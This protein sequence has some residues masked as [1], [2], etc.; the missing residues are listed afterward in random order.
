M[1]PYR[2]LTEKEIATMVV[3]G[4]SAEDWKNVT[5]AEN[6]NPQFVSNVS[7]SGVVKLGSFEKVFEM[8]GGFKKHSGIYN[9]CIHNCIIGNNVFID[10]VHNYIANYEICD[11]AFIENTNIIFVDGKTSFGNGL[12]VPVMNETGGREIPIF[13]ELSAPLAYILTFYRH[14]PEMIANIQKMIEDYAES[15]SS[16]M[17]RIG[18][19]VQ[20]VNCGRIKNVWI[21]DF[22]SIKGASNLKNGTINSNEKAPVRIGSG[23]KC[24]NFIISSGV[25]IT[26][27][28]LISTCFVGQGC[29]MDKHYSAL[30]S[31]F[32]SNCQGMHGE[33]TAIFAGPYTVSHHKSSLL[34]AGMY[35]FLNAGS[36]SNQSNH[37]YKLGPIHQ[38]V[39]ERGSKTTSDSYILWPAKIGAFTLVMGRHTS[40]SE[41]T[42]LPF[43]YL[44][45]N[46][47]ES[48]LVPAINLRSVGTV[49]D[50]QKWPKRD[51]RTDDVKLD[52]INFNLL[53]PY[54]IHKMYKGVET[55]EN[56][57]KISGETSEI[58]S[59]Q[60]CKIKNSSLNKA[61]ELYKIGI[62]KFLGNSLISK[63]EKEKPADFS[64][65]QQKLVNNTNK[66]L[67]D[68]ID[69]AGLIAP[70][71]EVY[72]M[73]DEI[74]NNELNLKQI[75]EKCWEFHNEYYNYEWTWAQ[76]KLEE[77]WQKP[78]N[79][80][81][82]EEIIDFI[83]R[84][85]SSV[86]K[87]DQL[88]Y[89]D[90]KKEFDL[91]SMTGFGVDGDDEQKKKDFVNV[92]GSFEK[93]PFVR[94]VLNHIEKKTALGKSTIE[95]VEKLS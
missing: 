93:N 14:R 65:L 23:V 62:Y 84:W 1:K 17:G 57:K 18:E 47:T 48:I 94:E 25:Q 63:I 56:L 15:V 79:E 31:V 20:I 33:A 32:F 91:T 77:Y 64:E 7:F 71:N 95:F 60:N 29:I 58:Y 19:K 13:N 40:H 8:A 87:L 4:C 43:S 2:S 52:P 27:S 88:L 72:T 5:V 16:T 78:I 36:G 83:E 41:T 90:A 44:I 59:Y 73:L 80:V 42:D 24:K 9:C 22:S 10:K 30:D 70:K 49:R 82:K 11:E 21:G 3:Y 39:V 34:I 68:W 35:S 46:A 6:F 89:E 45:E 75:L 74:E 51:N 85:K 54:T 61:L 50:A 81:N 92:R 26:D 67:G 66:G 55:L 76:Q 28:T 38:G 37:M 53:S 69:L 12:K 86:V